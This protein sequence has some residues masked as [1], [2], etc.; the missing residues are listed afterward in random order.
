MK[1]FWIKKV[2]IEVPVGVAGEDA[3]DLH[4]IHSLDE[5]SIRR[6]IRVC[7]MTLERKGVAAS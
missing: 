1:K 2:Y 3:I 7:E 4:Q 5:Q 6:I